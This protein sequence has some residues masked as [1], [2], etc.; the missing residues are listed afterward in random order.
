MEELKQMSVNSLVASY[1]VTKN[2]K[3]YIELCRRAING[4][5]TARNA[6]NELL[7]IINENTSKQ[8]LH[9]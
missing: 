3:V 4:D 9:G 5:S 6:I 7:N 2:E 8:I 1:K